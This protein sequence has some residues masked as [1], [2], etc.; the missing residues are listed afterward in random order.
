MSSNNDLVLLKEQAK[1]QRREQRKQ[2]RRQYKAQKNILK[3]HYV[4]QTRL[5]KEQTRQ[6][7][8]QT[9]QLKAQKYQKGADT[10][11]S[12][13]TYPENNL[14]YQRSYCAECTRQQCVHEFKPEPTESRVD[15]C[16][17]CGHSSGSHRPS[18]YSMHWLIAAHHVPQ[19]TVVD[20]WEADHT[21][22]PTPNTVQPISIITTTSNSNS[23]SS[24]NIANDTTEPCQDAMML[25]IPETPSAP[26]LFVAGGVSTNFA[27]PTPQ[28]SDS[29]I[30]QEAGKD[31]PNQNSK[32]VIMTPPRTVVH[33]VRST[34]GTVNSIVIGTQVGGSIK[35]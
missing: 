26:S 11:T 9:R 10:K 19:Y 32:P 23:N 35:M 8:E 7:K 4:E 34:G 22:Q 31:R 6:L 33:K 1:I 17:L 5:L 21:V 30:L 27:A 2:L 14:N 12:E 28:V 29:L 24:S 15:H 25:A 13:R 16:S 3:S 20:S 18:P